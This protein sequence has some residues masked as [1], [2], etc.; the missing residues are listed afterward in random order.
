MD[1]HEHMYEYVECSIG[2]GENRY[3]RCKFRHW[4]QMKVLH[5]DAFACAR[6]ASGVGGRSDGKVINSATT[7]IELFAVG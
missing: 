5:Q 4:E 3:H 2:H 6:A 7:D 1:G